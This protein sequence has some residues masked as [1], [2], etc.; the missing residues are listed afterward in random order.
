MKKILLALSLLLLASPAFATQAV[1][2]VYSRY[3]GS[4]F[5]L[6]YSGSYQ[7]Y[8]TTYAGYP[9]VFGSDNLG[10]SWTRQVY[11]GNIWVTNAPV[12]SPPCVPNIE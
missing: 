5:V 7:A 11:S 9:V 2:Y 1:S 4:W 10:R 8:E 12:C 3:D 6:T